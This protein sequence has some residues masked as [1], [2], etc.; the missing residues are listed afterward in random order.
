MIS[1]FLFMGLMYQ[2][3]LKVVL[4]WKIVLFSFFGGITRFSNFLFSFHSKRFAVETQGSFA[5]QIHRF[6]AAN[7]IQLV[8]YLVALPVPTRFISLFLT[9]TFSSRKAVSSLTPRIFAAKFFCR[10]P[11]LAIALN[12]C[13]CR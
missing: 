5:A 10:L 8:V 6:C 9:R 2:A 4:N 13:H 3:K 7:N 1:I 11:L 12:N